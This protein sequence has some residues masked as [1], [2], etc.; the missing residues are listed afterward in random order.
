MTWVLEQPW[1]RLGIPQSTHLATVGR[2][3]VEVE[4]VGRAVDLAA[5]VLSWRDHRFTA[6]KGPWNPKSQ[7]RKPWFFDHGPWHIGNSG[8]FCGCL[9]I[10]ASDDIN[11]IFWGETMFVPD[12]SDGKFSAFKFAPEKKKLGPEFENAEPRFILLAFSSDPQIASQNTLW[13]CLTVCYWKWW[14][15]VDLPINSMVI[16]HSYVSLPE[17]KW[18]L[19]WI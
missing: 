15:I 11:W 3:A 13:L 5:G 8:I 19:I 18:I 10:W 1:W 9:T 6:Q 17:G 12:P 7:G 2:I 4:T 16:L 14:F